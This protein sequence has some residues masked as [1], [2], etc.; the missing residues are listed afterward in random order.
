MS[1]LEVRNL[2]KTFGKIEAVR[3]VSFEVPEGGIFGLIGRN[4]A[5]KTTTIRMMMD[6]Y[7][8]DSGEVIFRGTKV[9]QDFRN[10]VGYLPEERGLYKKMKVLETLLYFAELKGKKGRSVEKK[11]KEY[12][13]RFELGARAMAKVE[14]LSKGNQQK[15]QFIATILHDPEFIILDEPFSGMDPINTNLL[16]EIILEQKR[17]NKVIIFSTHLMDFAEKMCDSIAM[18]DKGQLILSGALDQIKNRYSQQNVSLVYEGD[19]AFLRNSGI[20]EKIEDFG[21]STG[22]KLKHESSSQQLLKL[23]V[24]HNIVV[25]K[26]NANDISLHEIFVELAGTADDLSSTGGN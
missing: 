24:D 11:A 21:N 25:K 19:I 13:E 17:N 22:V 14:E 4:G 18:I 26:F 12:L 7:S 5:G 9:G 3:D 1:A 6:I 15:V 2:S 8:P 16:K 23:L 10:K 20:V